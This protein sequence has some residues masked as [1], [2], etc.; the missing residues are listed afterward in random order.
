MHTNAELINT[1]YTAFSRKDWQA[2][3][4]CYA[5][6]CTFAD[7]AFGPLRGKH[8]HAMWHML[9][10]NAQDF[11]LQ[12]F[13]VQADDVKGSC[14][15]EA[16]YT[17]SRTGRRV[18]NIIQAQFKFANGKIAVHDDTFDLWRWS[19]QALGTPGLLLGWSPIVQNKVRTTALQSLHKFIGTHP[20][21]QV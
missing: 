5:E 15:W 10:E 18:H 16:G 11:S 17:F 13:D 3:R 20:E 21:Y 6:G 2:M 4:T 14:R 19:R 1:F 7:P 9:C 8:V 12:Y